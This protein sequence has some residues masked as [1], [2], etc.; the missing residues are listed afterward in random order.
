MSG[1]WTFGTLLAIGIVVVWFSGFYQQLC[2]L[3]A[4]CIS[5]GM[6]RARRHI[7]CV[8]LL[9][10]EAT[11]RTTLTT[12]LIALLASTALA[13]TLPQPK[14][15]SPGGSCPFGYMS[16]GAFCIPSQG[17]QAAVPSPP[18]GSCPWG[19]TRSGSYCLRSGS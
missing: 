5:A 10:V 11:M 1:P 2:S 13:Q 14:P 4:G 6:G 9:C 16:S 8:C 19:W 18:N 15:G 17:A 7:A 3:Y 12:L